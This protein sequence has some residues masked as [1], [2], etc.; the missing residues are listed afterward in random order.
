L[1]K[2]RNRNLKLL[3][4]IGGWTYSS[5]FAAP[6]ATESGRRTFATSCV[7]LLKDLGLD[8]IDVDWEYP[9]N[10]QQARDLVALLATVRQELDAYATSL[11]QSPNGRPA[12]FYLT[13][14]APAGASNYEK[15]HLREMNPYLDFINL[16]A[17]DYAGS[18][19]QCAGHQGN[20]FPDPNHPECTPFST[21]AAVKHY[22]GQ[23]IPPQKMVIG[24]PLYGRSFMATDGPGKSYSGTGDG[25]WERGIWDYKVSNTLSITL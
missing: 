23:G 17:Y 14:A 9:Q 11:G 13:I 4:S 20:I 1:L 2:K 22:V 15:L 25:S 5:N 18:W 12:H 8:G 3:L 6:A 16:M 10:D 19:D 24:M 7:Q 21:A